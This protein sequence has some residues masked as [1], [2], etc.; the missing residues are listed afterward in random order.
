MTYLCQRGRRGDGN[1][2]TYPNRTLDMIAVRT[3]DPESGAA[4]ALVT[5]RW[6]DD[7]P[8]G[9]VLVVNP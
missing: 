9:S 4:R 2:L 3:L 1:H 6:R 7:A 8:G 5:H